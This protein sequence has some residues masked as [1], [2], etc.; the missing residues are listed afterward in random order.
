MLLLLLLLMMMLPLL[1]VHGA[2]LHWSP[3]SL[4]SLTCGRGSRERQRA[5]SPTGS[6]RGH[7]CAGPLKQSKPC[8]L[9]GCPG[10]N[11]NNSSSRQQI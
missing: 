1:T 6:S 3:W 8:S 5:C 9:A 10:N 4:C 11:N 2:W 7:R